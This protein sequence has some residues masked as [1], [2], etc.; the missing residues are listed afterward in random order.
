MIKGI[1]VFNI[2]TTILF[3]VALL[4]TYAFLPE[5]VK[6]Y[7]D[8]ISISNQSFFYYCL[9]IFGVSIAVIWLG[10]NVLTRNKK[11]QW[12][13]WLKMVISVLNFNFIFTIVYIGLMN[14]AQHVNLSAFG[15]L[16]YLGAI[17][18]A[19]W[20]VVLVVLMFSKK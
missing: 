7:Q 1:K 20:L 14:N 12:I 9:L 18:I 16:N 2:I 5:E 4:G 3:A 10:L 6:L 19:L 17:M 8:S 11:S 13:G 15:Y